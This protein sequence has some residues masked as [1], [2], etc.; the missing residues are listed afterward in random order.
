MQDEQ[1]INV[2]GANLKVKHTPGHT[3]DHV[4]LILEEEKVLFSGDCILGETTA[5]FE[6]LHDYMKSLEKILQENSALIYPGHGPVVSDPNAKI[7]AYI[8][9]RN[10]RE[11]QILDF[12]ESRGKET[13]SDVMDIVEFMYKV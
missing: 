6:D 1:Q 13:P 2:Q 3:S 5:V 4:C 10:N 8:D 9:H 7:R 11:R 12:L